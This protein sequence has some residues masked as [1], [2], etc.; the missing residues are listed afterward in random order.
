MDY[1]SMFYEQMTIH[2]TH[3]IDINP[4][5]FE[6]DNNDDSQY[7]NKGKMQALQFTVYNL[8]WNAFEY[9]WN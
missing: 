8:N 1:L 2:L 7:L 4:G 5:K 6:M 3:S 9:G